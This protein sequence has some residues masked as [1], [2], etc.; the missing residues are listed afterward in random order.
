LQA[1]GKLALAEPNRNVP[2]FDN[3]VYSVFSFARHDGAA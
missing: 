3:T 2:Y 1:S